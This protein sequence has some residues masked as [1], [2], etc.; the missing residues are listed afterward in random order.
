MVAVE[1]DPRLAARLHRRFAASGVTVVEQDLLRVPL[2]GRRYGVVASIPFAIT[3]PLLGR[4]LDPP[5]SAL[6][7]AVLVVEHGAAKR[8]G[9]ARSGDARVLWWRARF[10]VSVERHVDA[11]SFSPPPSVNA[12]VLVLQRRSSPLVPREQQGPFLGL[13]VSALERRRTTTEDAFATVFSRRQLRRLLRDLRLDPQQP[14]GLLT[15]EQWAMITATMVTH[16]D[17]TRWPRRRPSWP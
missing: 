2:P 3:T 16:V 12:A 7:R 13:L 5:G 4:L 8:F 17:S 10:G 14:V 11:T 1:R 6:G 9:D 15:I